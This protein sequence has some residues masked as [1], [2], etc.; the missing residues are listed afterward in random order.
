[1]RISEWS[2]D[3]CSSDLG[4]AGLQR[5]H[6]PPPLAVAAHVVPLRYRVAANVSALQEDRAGAGLVGFVL[7]HRDHLRRARALGGG[8]ALRQRQQAAGRGQIG[9]AS[10]RERVWQSVSS[11]LAAVALKT[12]QRT[13]SI[14]P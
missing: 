7:A 10:G 4:Q 6:D 13:K 14:P 3:V 2:S 12:K 9:R 1:M 8:R 11:S 5:L